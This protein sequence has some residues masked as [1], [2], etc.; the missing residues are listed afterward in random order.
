VIERAD[1]GPER[2]L[3]DLP[4]LAAEASFAF[5]CHPGVDC[6]GDCCAG[7]DLVLSPYDVLRLRRALGLSGR[8]FLARHAQVTFAGDTGMPIVRLAMSDAPGEPCPF[9]GARGCTVYAERPSPCRIYPLGRGTRL[10]ENGAR[11]ETYVLVREPHCRGFAQARSWTPRTWSAD[12]GLAEYDAAN[13]AFM[14]LLAGLGDSGRR[15]SVDDQREALHALYRPDDFAPFQDGSAWA[16]LAVSPGQRE[17][18]AADEGARLELA[19]RWLAQRWRL[20]HKGAPAGG[21]P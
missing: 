21:S 1:R 2:L 9:L 7:L 17:R 10:D 19:L 14:I 12:Q 4:R 20:C 11:V 5:A 8:A 13:D 15:L 3:E 6:F 16:A 18:L